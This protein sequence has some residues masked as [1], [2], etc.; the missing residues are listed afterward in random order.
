MN[1]IAPNDYPEK[2]LKERREGVTFYT[3]VVAPTGRAESCVVRTSSG[4]KD[5]DDRA[6]QAAT[7]RARFLPATDRMGS[8]VTGKFDYG[9]RWL[10]QPDE[11][12][13][14]PPNDPHLSVASARCIHL[15]Y[16][17]GGKGYRTCT[18]EQL[19]LLSKEKLQKGATPE[20]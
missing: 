20:P 5:L 7:T 18:S 4:H 3:L 10:V 9:I 14:P 6:C 8:P 15:G 2:A 12:G 16:K 19:I 1:W 13:A 17:V 11:P